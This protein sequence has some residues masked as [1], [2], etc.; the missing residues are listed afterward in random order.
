MKPFKNPH[1]FHSGLPS[2]LVC[3]LL[4]SLG[5][6]LSSQTMILCND[7]PSHESHYFLVLR[8]RKPNLGDLVVAN[9]PFLPGKVIK[10]VLAKGNTSLVLKNLPVRDLPIRDNS[11]DRFV[12]QSKTRDGRVLTPIATEF[13]TIPP[14]FCFLYS[15]HPR[16]FDS[17]YREMGLV[18]ETDLLGVAYPIVLKHCLGKRTSETA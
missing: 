7:S 6:L 17:R 13:I 10:T 15:S 4:G 14:G 18:K 12:F 1:R 5:W 8:H 16:S 2:L 3:S 11:P 9:S